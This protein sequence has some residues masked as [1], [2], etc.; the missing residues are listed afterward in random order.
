MFPSGLLYFRVFPVQAS[1]EPIDM[2]QM[3]RTIRESA[4]LGPTDRRL[5]STGGSTQRPLSSRVTFQPVR[6]NTRHL[7]LAI[8]NRRSRTI[9]GQ[10]PGRNLARLNLS[11]KLAIL[12]GRGLFANLLL[13]LE[14]QFLFLLLLTFFRGLL[15]LGGHDIQQLDFEH[16]Q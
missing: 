10:V 15:P 13:D 1:A 9:K 14:I 11:R 7:T 6:F 2:D 12:C 8:P 16:K 3:R 4:G 5:S